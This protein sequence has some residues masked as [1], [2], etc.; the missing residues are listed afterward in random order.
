MLSRI[1]DSASV[2]A[3]SP[4]VVAAQEVAP[5]ARMPASAAL[6]STSSR[7]RATGV[8]SAT[9]S[10]DVIV[11]ARFRIFPI[12]RKWD[13]I[14]RERVWLIFRDQGPLRPLN[15]FPS[16]CGEATTFPGTP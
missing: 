8:G 16:T 7:R 6:A 14:D 12:R 15:H 9:P 3:T 10:S 13:H 11:I 2:A 5:I 4:P 1:G